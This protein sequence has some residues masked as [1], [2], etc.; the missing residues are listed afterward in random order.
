MGPKEWYTLDMSPTTMSPDCY[1]QFRITNKPS[2]HVFG[3]SEEARVPRE[4]PHMNR[5]NM[6][7]LNRKPVLN[8]RVK[9]EPPHFRAAL[10]KKQAYNLCVP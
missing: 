8:C 2:L 10:G 4:S 7:T 1:S 5:K 6:Q 3:L 9:Y